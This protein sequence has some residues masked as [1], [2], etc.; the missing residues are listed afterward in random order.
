M[1]ERAVIEARAKTLE[2]R[3][4]TQLMERAKVASMLEQMDVAIHQMRGALAM[5]R[6]LLT[7]TQPLEEPMA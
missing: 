3:L 7:D 4:Q 2:E 5:L 6:E 1:V